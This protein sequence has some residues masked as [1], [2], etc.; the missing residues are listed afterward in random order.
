M[1]AVEN[2]KI[3]SVIT[4]ALEA[5]GFLK[6]FAFHN[7]GKHYQTPFTGLSLFSYIYWIITLFLQLIFLI[8]V[9]SDNSRIHNEGNKIVGTVG[10]HFTVSNL[11]S[12]FW[13]YYFKKEK[14]IICEI[15]LF[16]NLINLL[17]LYIVHKTVSIKSI[18]E[19]IFI[20][21]P[22][23]S[24]PLSWT[25]YAI[26]WNGAAMFHSHNKSLLARILANVFI[27]EFLITPGAF[28]IFHND[29]SVGLASSFLTFGVGLNQFFTKMI[30]FQ[31]IFAFVIAGLL[32][33]FSLFTLF[34]VFKKN[35][36]QL[37]SNEQ[38]PLLA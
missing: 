29:W 15:L 13:F 1:T 14:F 12:F 34:G 38:A 7:S 8:G 10:Y 4:F 37:T 24:L 11:I 2:Q 26:F 22:I 18:K 9:L 20:H 27:W 6:Y 32:F 17:S 28:L 3:A 21:L 5:Y 16:V 19:W 36:N 25:L 33:I 23:T 31:W 35:N 30:A